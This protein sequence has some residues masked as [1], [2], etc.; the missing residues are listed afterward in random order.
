MAEEEKHTLTNIDHSD[1][2]EKIPT[3][4]KNLQTTP[5]KPT[6]IN[7]DGKLN[8]EVQINSTLKTITPVS[9]LT[10]KFQT[11]TDV[12]LTTLNP[13][14]IRMS[15]EPENPLTDLHKLIE[16][17]KEKFEFDNKKISL[18][19]NLEMALTLNHVLS[20]CNDKISLSVK[21]EKSHK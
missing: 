10:K 4:Q 3:D 1:F 20:Q 14:P 8:K 19:A 9:P 7:T 12:I 16:S 13:K 11:I 18:L 6:S 5:K 2:T 21:Q 17:E 15:K